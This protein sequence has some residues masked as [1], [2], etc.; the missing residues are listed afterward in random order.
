MNKKD[1][2]LF[3]VSRLMFIVPKQHG[4]FPFVL[5]ACHPLTLPDQVSPLSIFLV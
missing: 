4:T 5:G 1:N 3:I 2:M